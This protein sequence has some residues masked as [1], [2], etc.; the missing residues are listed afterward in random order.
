MVYGITKVIA[1]HYDDYKAS[2]PG[3]NGW[4]ILGQQLQNAFIPYHDGAVR[5]FREIGIWTPEAEA[6]QQANLHRQQV[7]MN[8][9]QAYLPNA[10]EDRSQFEAGWLT[11]REQALAA[12]GLITL[13]DT[14]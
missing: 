3:A 7:L 1:M 13:S 11:F 14:Q 6:R 2:A 8:A 4:R 10:A 5:Y 12:Q 9:W